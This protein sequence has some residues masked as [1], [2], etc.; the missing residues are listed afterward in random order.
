MAEKINRY[1]ADLRDMR[2]L[3][4]EQ[5]KV[6]DLLGAPPYA[7]WAQE[8]CEMVLK[9]VYKWVQDVPGPLNRSGDVEGC[10]FENGEV[11]TPT[12][13]KEAWKSL[14]EVGWRGLSAPEKYGGQGAPFSLGMLVT[15]MI[16]GSNT[17]F[18]MYSG[19]TAGVFEVVEA[20]G[21][22][23]QVAAYAQKLVEGEYAGTMCLT[24]PQAGSDVGASVTKATPTGDGT[25]K[26]QGTKIYISGGQH[27]LT[28]NIIHL[29]LA[30]TPG[31][32]EG[33]K[34]LSLF[35]VPRD[36]EDGS[37]ND[38]SCGSIEHKMGIKGS[39][40]AVL[41]FGENDN[42]IGQL[43]GAEEQQGMR[44]MFKMMNFARI[45][46][47]VQGLAVA[48]SAYLN[49]LEYARERKQGP[50]M[51]QWK[52]PKAPKVPII[53]HAN[54]RRMLLDMKC[55]VEGIRSLV[56]KLSSHIDAERVFR[57][58]DEAAAAYHQGQV[59]LLVPLVKA[60]ASDEGF[61]ITA[62][63]IQ[64]F[65]GAG[66]LTDHPVEQYCRDAKIF[67]IY[68]GTNHIQALDLVGRKLGQKGG[69]NFQ[70]YL[71]DIATFVAANKD[72]PVHGPTVETLGLAQQAVAGSAMRLLGWFQSGK[73]EMVTVNANRFLQ[74]MA[75]TT[76]G[77]MLLDG[78]RVAE[79][80]IEKL[81]EDHPNAAF[82]LGRRYSALFF[83]GIYLPRV[84]NSSAF[85]ASGGGENPL[86][87][88]DV[89]F[90]SM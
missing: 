41:N 55:R 60:Y 14:N 56:V 13:F 70:A 67:S 89:G 45:A 86:K 7:D 75:I 69:A 88:S 43:V 44:Q 36:N 23:S 85:M 34:G 22:E 42:C 50:S 78:A 84:V 62:T 47:G 6:N 35:I 71:K 2:F 48:G 72:H 90:G 53:Q 59:D 52:D 63:A 30:R 15:E 12:G 20:F 38:V 9:E 1:R 61:D 31:A 40:T 27:D 37:S 8:E 29:V 74:M 33:T 81:G 49:A 10:H 51:A 87:I 66:Y 28:P 19:L 26:I 64:V 18:G 65:G 58:K 5:F 54:V 4:F 21:T 39:S 32:P 17:S 57:E 73:A 25:Y 46:V 79:D 68:E 3:L 16:S 77:W 24:E 83:G 80:A 11:R 76:V 82:Y